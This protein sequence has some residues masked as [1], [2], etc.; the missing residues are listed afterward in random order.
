MGMASKCG[1]PSGYF[2]NLAANSDEDLEIERND[3][4]D[5][6]RAVTGSGGESCTNLMPPSM[7]LTLLR[8]LLQA[9]EQ[10]ILTSRRSH[11]LFDETVLHAFSAL[12]ELSCL[13]F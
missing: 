12:G 10:S 4:R 2:E 5:L 6:L 1:Y 7:T 3:V 13:R 9:C 11:K 8:N